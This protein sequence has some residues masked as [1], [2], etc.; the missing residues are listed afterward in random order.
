MNN[1]SSISEVTKTGVAILYIGTSWCAYCKKTTQGLDEVMPGH[2]DV[3]VYHI[4]GDDE[5]DALTEV[6]GK[7]YPQ[8]LLFRDGEKVA[9][10]ESADGP[11]LSEWLA[12]NGVA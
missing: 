1:I 5:P 4:D 2:P 3:Q 11:Q 6:N 7:S 8:I 12:A 10:R 9:Q